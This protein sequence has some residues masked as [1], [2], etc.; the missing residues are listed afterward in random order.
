MAIAHRQSW[1]Q[2]T[3]ANPAVVSTTSQTGDLLIAWGVSDSATGTITFPAGFGTPVQDATTADG[4]TIAYAIKLSAGNNDSISIGGGTL[5]A[6]VSAFTGCDQASQPDATGTTGKTDSLGDGNSVHP[7]TQTSSGPTTDVDGCMLIAIMGSDNSTGGSV[8]HSFSG[9]GSWSVAADVNDSLFRH[10]AL[11][12]L[13]QAIA[14]AAGTITG[15]G[16]EGSGNHA[17]RVL[18][19]LALKPA[20][21]PAGTGYPIH[22]EMVF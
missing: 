18:F 11:G 17:A 10:A 19:T 3:A 15:Q 12:Y 7:W 20:A 8:T 2:E 14:G 4:M 9:G 5:C 1:K 16:S 21:A 22:S 13:L 6:G